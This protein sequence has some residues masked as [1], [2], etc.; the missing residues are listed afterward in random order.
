VR[1]LARALHID[2]NAPFGGYVGIG[3]SVDLEGMMV[4]T[5]APDA[6][7]V[8]K[9]ERIWRTTSQPRRAAAR[10]AAFTD[11]SI[12]NLSSIALHIDSGASSALLTGDARGDRLLAG[13]RE[14]ELLDEFGRIRVSLL[15]L[16][17]HGSVNNVTPEFFESVRAD[18]YVISTD[19]IKYPKHPGLDVLN[20]IVS[21]R[22]DDE[23]TIH[24]TNPVPPAVAR[25]EELKK[26]NNFTVEIREDS[27]R[28]V[29]IEL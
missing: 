20:W 14:S 9:L 16:P 22:H 12:P 11:R 10:A 2:G 29:V 23:F 17:H 26:R 5:L 27:E 1:D 4:T 18:H 3:C 15:K 7:A 8:A 24:M 13:L 28:A 25:L 19:G 21:S 6:G